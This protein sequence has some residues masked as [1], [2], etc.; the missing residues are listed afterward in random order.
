MFVAQARTFLA[1]CGLIIF[2][3]GESLFKLS[4]LAWRWM[5]TA[6][7]TVTPTTRIPQTTLYSSVSRGV[8]RQQDNTSHSRQSAGAKPR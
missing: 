8:A 5:Y 6:A 7:P 4:V 2:V 3:R 1:L